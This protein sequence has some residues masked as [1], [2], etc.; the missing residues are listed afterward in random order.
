M[1]GK[2]S[3]WSNTER[4]IADLTEKRARLRFFS[5]AYWPSRRDVRT[6]SMGQWLSN[7]ILRVKTREISSRIHDIVFFGVDTRCIYTQV[8][9]LHLNLK[10]TIFHYPIFKE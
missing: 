7:I 5:P 10:Q 6:G 4:I 8:F 2:F 3:I 1:S 9:T